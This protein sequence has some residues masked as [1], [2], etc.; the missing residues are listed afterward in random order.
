MSPAAPAALPLPASAPLPAEPVL[1]R[2]PLFREPLPAEKPRLAA[3]PPLAALPLS[4]PPTFPAGWGAAAAAGD[5]AE[6]EASLGGA[7]AGAAAGGGPPLP[8]PASKQLRMA[9]GWRGL[10]SGSSCPSSPLPSG[11]SSG[12]LAH[13]TRTAGGGPRATCCGVAAASAA[14]AVGAPSLPVL[15]VLNSGS[16]LLGAACAAGPSLPSHAAPA[17]SAAPC[18]AACACASCT[19]AGRPPSLS[20]AAVTAA[21]VWSRAAVGRLCARSSAMLGLQGGKQCGRG[22]AIREQQPQQFA[23]APEEL[24]AIDSAG[25]PRLSGSLPMQRCATCPSTC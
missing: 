16:C 17:A 1:G 19:A 3:L 2:L 23:A 24:S 4:P 11:L 8:V 25:M 6:G 22:G 12:F 7:A 15:P 9:G 14:A 5:E 21:M 18:S 10:L 20:T 13:G